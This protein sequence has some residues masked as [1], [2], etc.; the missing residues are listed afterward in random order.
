MLQQ[1]PAA[2]LDSWY[3]CDFIQVL[4]DEGLVPVS[5]VDVQRQWIEIDTPQDLER[6]NATVQYLDNPTSATRRVVQFGRLLRAEANDLKRPLP[7][8]T[9]EA[10][11]EEGV[12]ERMLAGQMDVAEA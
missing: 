10:G 6:A 5:H 9:A 7:L 2:K 4:L 11:L 8:L 12:V 3:L 1:V